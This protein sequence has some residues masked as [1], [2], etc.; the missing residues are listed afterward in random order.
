[1]K[2]VFV[3]QHP[4][5]AHLIQGVLESQGIGAEVRSE[6]LFAVRGEAPATPDTLPSVWVLDDGDVARAL[7]VLRDMRPGSDEPRGETWACPSCGEALE[8]QFAACW[9]CGT[10]RPGSS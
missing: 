10:S 9:Q 3:A 5:E 1:M 2:Q 4:T 6:A 7:A 8:P